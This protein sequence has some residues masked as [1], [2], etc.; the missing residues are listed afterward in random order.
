M[1]NIIGAG[2]DIAMSQFMRVPIN[3]LHKGQDV[4]LYECSLLI[5]LA[6]QRP[7]EEQT[8]IMIRVVLFVRLHT[9]TRQMNDD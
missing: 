2:S 6:R 3:L 7:F 9:I 5:A 8:V 4:L 1:D